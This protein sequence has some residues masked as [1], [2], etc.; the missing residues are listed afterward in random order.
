MSYQMPKYI[1][2]DVLFEQTNGCSNSSSVTVVVTLFNYAALLPTCLKSIFE[3]EHKDLDLIIVDDCSNADNSTEVALNWL[4]EHA[5]RFQKAQLIRHR[6]N[7]GAA[8]SKNTGFSY[9]R[10][11]RAFLIDADNAIYPRA[12]K[13]LYEAMKNNTV[14]AAYSQL[15]IFGEKTG[16]GMADV[17]DV[18]R[19]TVKPYIDGMA[20][21][22][23]DAWHTVGGF[24]EIKGWEDYDFWCKFAE[25][26]FVA[27]FVPEILCRYRK[28]GASITSQYSRS[29]L[30]TL[31]TQATFRHP[32][33]R[34]GGMKWE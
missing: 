16:L 18:N 10:T 29:N 13:R 2:H 6:R 27:A 20:L 14:Q 4:T 19:L 5:S 11:E 33:L 34:L 23:I 17:W 21:Y 15:E 3:Q 12:I 30:P 22:A 7:C 9:A 8:Q 31:Y 25:H 26:G 28:H 24:T 1:Q 32:W